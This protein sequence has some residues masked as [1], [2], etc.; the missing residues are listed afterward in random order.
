MNVTES[1]E[2]VKGSRRVT[3]N[4]YPESDAH[5]ARGLTRRWL[6]AGAPL[7]A[8]GGTA[9][10]GA[11]ERGQAPAGSPTSRSGR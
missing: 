11:V 4:Q 2:H 10:A 3:A 6:L 8:A 9:E 1:I 7:A 5:R